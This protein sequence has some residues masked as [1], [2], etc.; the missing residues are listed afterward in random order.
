MRKLGVAVVAVAML[1]VLAMPRQAAAED[2]GIIAL[3]QSVALLMSQLADLQKSFNQQMG[4]MQGLV[5]QNTDTV[6][7]LAGTLATIQHTLSGNALVTSQNQNNISQQFQQ[8]SDAVAALKAQMQQMDQT[9]Q[10][11]HQMQQTIPPSAAAAG[12]GTN[13]NG[14]APGGGLPNGAANPVSAS[15]AAASPLQQYQQALN[16][17]QSGAP[18]AQVELARFIRSNPAAPQVPDATYFLGTVFMNNGQYNEAVDQFNTLIEMYPDNAK[19]PLAELNK[20]ISLEKMG[21]RAA[22]ISEFRALS[23]NHPGTQAARQADVELHR[24]ERKR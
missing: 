15:G 11:V 4:M 21:N 7:K 17:F 23:K 22:A 6:N 12:S 18:Q 5:T 19:T 13:G 24:L 8:L 1:A 14:T 16:D 2:K 3:Q 10:Q 9:L 20:G